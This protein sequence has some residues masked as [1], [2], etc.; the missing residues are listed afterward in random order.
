MA[1]TRDQLLSQT[2]RFHLALR[3]AGVDADLMVFEGMLHA[4]WAYMECP[5]TDDALAA[6][7]DFYSRHL[8]A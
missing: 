5:E 8:A 6:Q 4:F 3:K 7:A 1:S 2:V